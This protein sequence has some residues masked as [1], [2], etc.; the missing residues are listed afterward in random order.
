MLVH[1]WRCDGYKLPRQQKQADPT[2]IALQSSAGSDF[3]APHLVPE[4]NV[5][6]TVEIDNY[7]C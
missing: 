5:S 7:S 2:G 1:N 3:E 4:L 6:P